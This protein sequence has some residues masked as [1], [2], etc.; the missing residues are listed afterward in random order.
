MFAVVDIAGFQEMVRQGDQLDVPLQASEAGKVIK[1][2]KVLLVAA[3]DTDVMV[4][5][6]LLAGAFVEAKVIEHGRG[7]KI[8][9]SKMRRRK[10][11]RRVHGHRQDF[12]TIEITKITTK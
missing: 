11:Y 8:R 1:F 3:S 6:P 10:R 5:A 2:D 4:G 7:D 9:V 12:T